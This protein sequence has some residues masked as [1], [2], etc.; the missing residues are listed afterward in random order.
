MLQVKQDFT[1]KSLYLLALLLSVYIYIYKTLNRQEGIYNK[2]K[3]HPSCLTT[4]EC[5]HLRWLSVKGCCPLSSEEAVLF[6]VFFS[7][8]SASEME[9]KLMV[10]RAEHY[11]T[12]T[13]VLSSHQGC[14]HS[15][16]EINWCEKFFFF[17]SQINGGIDV[18]NIRLKVG[19]IKYHK[20]FS[21]VYKTATLLE[22]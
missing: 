13:T 3:D 19:C 21:K 4:P 18:V 12:E 20:S 15:L 9:C 2:L 11:F 7:C 14:G 1:S 10:E 16:K 22:L 8:K 17:P 5:H 6:F